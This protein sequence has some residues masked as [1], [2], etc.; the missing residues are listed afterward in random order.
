MV[1][2]Y[3][4]ILFRNLWRD[5]LFSSINILGL[6][7]GIACT[8]LIF[9]YVID[10]MSYDRFHDHSDRIFRVCLAANLGDGQEID[11]AVV[12]APVAQ[13][14]VRE[15]P[16]V[17][18]A[19]RIYSSGNL[20]FNYSDN[21]MNES[22]IY[23]ADPN[24]F[25]VL[26]FKLL[27]GDP[28]TVL[29][30]PNSIVLR[31]NTARKYFGNES[32]LGKAI[33]IEDVSFKVTGIVSNSQSNSHF[34]FDG[35]ISMI[36]YS[37]SEGTNWGNNE[38]YTYVKLN[39]G[40]TPAELQEKFS[41]LE[42]KYI[43]PM[44]QR[45]LG[46]S[47]TDFE[48]GGGYYGYY[49]QPIT[50]IHLFSH[51]DSELSSNGNISYIYLLSVV[52]FF[53]ILIASINFMN[54]STAKST[55]RA[56]EVGI[57][58]TLGSK[59]RQL[60]FQFLLESFVLCA[61]SFLLAIGIVKLFIE[62]FNDVIGKTLEFNL[63]VHWKTIIGAILALP[64]LGLL[65]GSYPAF[66][67]T[68]INTVDT[69]KGK[70]RTG[71]YGKI[72]RNG[73]VI[74]Q[75]AVSVGLIFF[76]LV[77]YKQLQFMR[78]VNIG[79]EKDRMVVISNSNNRLETSLASFKQA[80]LKHSQ[81]KAVSISSS[82]PVSSALYNK[83]TFRNKTTDEDIILTVF[84][85][86]E[87]FLES[88]KL[89]LE[90]GRNFHGVV[91][92]EVILN[93]VAVKRLKLE[94]PIGEIL[95]LDGNEE[96]EIVG[97]VMDFH[98][99]SLH[100]NIEPLIIMQDDVGGYISVQ[101]NVNDPKIIAGIIQKEWISIAPDKPLEYSFL[102]DDYN[103]LFRSELRLGKVVGIFTTLTIF[104]ACLGLL[105]LAVFMS[106]RRQK[107]ISIRKILGAT[108][109][110]ILLLLG[111]D[112]TKLVIIAYFIGTPLGFILINWWLRGFV[113]KTEIGIDDIIIP[114]ILA[115]FAALVTVSYQS[116]KVALTVPVN[117][118][119]VE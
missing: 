70:L 32:A 65:A 73:L 96:Y 114:G 95:L 92:N 6:T 66:Y 101:S 97:V 84:K 34:V 37:G 19:T 49:L 88:Y 53:T 87:N 24:F 1:K 48:N 52:A 42:E 21:V 68:S 109:K 77:V 3:L 29:I 63:N 83:T 36:S 105:G 116:I 64:I 82:V 76:T 54:L 72:I 62:P 27:K 91:K 58:K 15:F 107:E 80:L 38:F 22:A 20:T 93:E 41:I 60:S 108:F 94:N 56:L 45:N 30:E 67:L 79:F 12:S 50:K 55:N 104:I 43:G 98:Y 23:F 14:F 112:F 59:K 61:I 119:K 10:E 86:D 9:L 99:K 11:M 35:L 7:I 57:R 33:S 5:K 31:E 69:L 4:K 2:N 117:S 25:E 16:D 102:E 103:N 40:F 13:S 39:E 51:I 46:F 113:Y 106:E 44:V 115:L 110:S 78:Q 118:L 85:A 71:N 18:A 8:L 81:I 89:Q 17:E 111:K 47:Y 26:N 74:F 100:Y 90:M 28:K 75:F